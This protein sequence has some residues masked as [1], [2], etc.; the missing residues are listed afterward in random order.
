[1]KSKNKKVKSTEIDNFHP[2]AVLF[3]LDDGSP[4]IVKRTGNMWDWDR[5]FK[6]DNDYW[7]DISTANPFEFIFV[8]WN[9]DKITTDNSKTVIPNESFLGLY[10]YGVLQGMIEDDYNRRYNK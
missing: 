8:F 7:P 6:L 10:K 3:K 9:L 1:M 4:C 2:N 5:T